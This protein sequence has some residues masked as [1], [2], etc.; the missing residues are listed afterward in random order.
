MT[1][2]A[3]AVEANG[4]DRQNAVSPLLFPC[5][6]VKDNAELDPSC[7]CWD[8]RTRS[9]CTARRASQRP[10]CFN[11]YAFFFCCCPS[12]YDSYEYRAFDNGGGGGDKLAHDYELFY[13]AN[14]K[15]FVEAKTWS[16]QQQ[17]N[18]IISPLL[19]FLAPFHH[20]PHLSLLP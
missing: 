18:T 4:A 17:V 15:T 6:I 7:L 1:S 10:N 14:S 9:C 11:F 12:Y 16:Q 19:P 2:L 3:R 5:L 20:A 13:D 8:N